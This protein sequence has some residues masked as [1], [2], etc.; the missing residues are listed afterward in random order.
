[1]NHR[2]NPDD[3][4]KFVIFLAIGIALSILIIGLRLFAPFFYPIAW[5]I[6]LTLFFY[7]VF[8]RINRILKGKEGI[9]ALCMCLIIISFIIIPVF[10]L[11]GSLANEVLRVYDEFQAAISSKGP[12]LIPDPGAHPLL[13]RL[14]SNLFSMF[15]IHGNI[16]PGQFMTDLVKRFSESF[17]AQGTVVFKNIITVVF[18]G[19][20][21]LVVLFYLFRD[22][23]KFLDTFKGVLPFHDVEIERFFKII[24]D[25]LYATLYGNILTALIQ[26]GLGV[27]ILWALG[28]SA[29]LLWGIVMG[30]A[31]F[32]PIVGT[33]LVWVPATLYLFLAGSY[34]KGAVLLIFSILLISQID[35]FLRP[36]LISGKTHLHS[37]FLFFSILG[38]L[39]VFGLLGL[40]LGPIIIA[41]CVSILEIYRLNYLGYPGNGMKRLLE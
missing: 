8:Q 38:G 11:L 28:F 23:E 13:N 14:L 27:F 34:L 40:V 41:L 25:V 3:T 7:P 37:L 1:M 15:N 29:P 12:G 31:T 22:G 9:S 35:Y 20:L 10:I 26:A 18:D 17:I 33:A 30:I 36:Y 21:M 32:I 6:V 24:S 39:N 5:A 16:S 19:L 2:Y 4:Q